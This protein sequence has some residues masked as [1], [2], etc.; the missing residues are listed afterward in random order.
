MEALSRSIHQM[1]QK[2]DCKGLRAARG[3][4]LVSHLLFADDLI[5]FGEATSRQAKCMED[6]MRN[7]CLLSGQEVS[8]SKSQLFGLEMLAD[9]WPWF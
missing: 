7:F 1:V 4:P 3:E 6:V 2:G 5:L 9:R 8:N